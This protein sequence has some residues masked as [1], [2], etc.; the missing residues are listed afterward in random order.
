MNS[1]D[2]ERIWWAPVLACGKL[3]VE[4]LP[5]NFPGEEPVGAPMLVQ[6]VRAALNIRFQGGGLPAPTVMWTDRG[7]G[8]FHGNGKITTEFQ[9]A[10]EENDLKHFWKDD[11][12]IQPGQLQ[13]VH[14]HETA[15]SWIRYQ[16][17]LST[18]NNA[19]K[20]TREQYTSRLKAC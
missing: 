11:A 17:T 16:L 3:H 18:P 4:V 5:E 13:E 10:L 6:R 12:A 7:K 1:W 19:W 20:E 15:V 8:F 9:A 14:L 2:T